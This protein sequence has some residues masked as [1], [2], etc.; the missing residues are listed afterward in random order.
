M[1]KKSAITLISVAIV[2]VSGFGAVWQPQYDVPEDTNSWS[3]YS[4]GDLTLDPG[5]SIKDKRAWHDEQLVVF[6]KTQPPD[7]TMRILIETEDG[8][9]YWSA[10]TKGEFKESFFVTPGEPYLV[11]VT[12]IGSESVIF[13]E[14]MFDAVWFFDENGK[15]VWSGHTRGFV[16]LIVTIIAFSVAIV[17]WILAKRAGEPWAFKS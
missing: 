4:K 3:F 7:S 2:F 17:S 14:F 6:F 5:E 12:N 1:T 11:T 8:K 13:S 15:F 9:N 16:L 10:D